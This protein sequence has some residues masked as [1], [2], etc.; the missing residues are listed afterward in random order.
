[1]NSKILILLLS[2]HK[3]PSPRN[4]ISQIN[5]WIKTAM[6]RGLKVINFIGGFDK[7]NL[8]NSY[9]EL[10]S[11]DSIEAVGYKTLEAFEWVINKTDYEYIFRVNSSSYVDIDRL[12]TFINNLDTN[13]SNLN[14][15]YCGK[16]VNLQ[17]LDLNFISGSA[18]LFNRECIKKLVENKELWNH[19]IIDDVALGLLC[20]E[21]SILPHEGELY[22]IKKLVYTDKNIKES[23]HYR[24]K[25]EEF[26]YPRYLESYNIIFLH[27]YLK[28]GKINKLKINI[29]SLLF[30]F[31]KFI[32]IKHYL[33]KYIFMNRHLRNSLRNYKNK[34]LES[35]KND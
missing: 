3:Y 33:N 6:E 21:L 22:H 26:G 10:T 24:C 23:Y 35:F 30:Q 17:M 4:E 8:N 7:V 16:I 34:F 19:S 28:N 32:N 20:K 18:I 29:I 14:N 15:L 1:M 12:I 31:L 13:N 11:E 25:L 2:S 9:L 27:N 5:T